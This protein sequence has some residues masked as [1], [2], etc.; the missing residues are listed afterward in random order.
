MMILHTFKFIEM[1]LEMIWMEMQ[2]YM[3]LKYSI[4]LMQLMMLNYERFLQT[5]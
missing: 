3:V 4:L 5:L 1:Y 2:D